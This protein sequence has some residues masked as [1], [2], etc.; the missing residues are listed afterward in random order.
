M[1]EIFEDYLFIDIKLKEESFIL[2]WEDLSLLS[3]LYF[4]PENFGKM[5]NKKKWGY[6]QQNIQAMENHCE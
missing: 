5:I 6:F 3:N 2:I 4:T 1:E